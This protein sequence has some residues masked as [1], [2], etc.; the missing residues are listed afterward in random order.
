MASSVGLDGIQEEKQS[1][2]LLF[3]MI[4]ALKFLPT[5][6]L[7]VYQSLSGLWLPL[8]AAKATLK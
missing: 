8:A 6:R 4:Y 7:K 2:G 5:V 3:L 1:I